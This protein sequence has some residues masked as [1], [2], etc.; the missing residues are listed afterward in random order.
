MAN[1]IYYGDFYT[2]GSGSWV[3]EKDGLHF[4][5]YA[6]ITKKLKTA[7]DRSGNPRIYEAGQYSQEFLR[8]LISR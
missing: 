6:K 8:S 7:A 4:K 2:K 5:R 1:A 3:T